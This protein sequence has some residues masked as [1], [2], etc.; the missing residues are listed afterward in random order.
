ML[1]HP[2]RQPPLGADAHCEEEMPDDADE[3]E[4]QRRAEWTRIYARG[5]VG[6]SGQ[7][8]GIGGGGAAGGRGGAGGGAE[9]N[10]GPQEGKEGK[11]QGGLG[12]DDLAFAGRTL[13]EAALSS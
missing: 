6:P 2:M 4:L 12:E 9:G 5:P 10:E 11:E 8:R 1:K 3:D 13:L 7:Y